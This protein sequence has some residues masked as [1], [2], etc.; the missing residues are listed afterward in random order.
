MYEKEQLEAHEE[1]AN[2]LS[3]LDG[4]RQGE[5]MIHIEAFEYY[6][7]LGN[8]RTC[9]LVG[10]K[11]NKN[12]R[13]ISQW[14][15]KFNWVERVKMRDIE[16]SKKLVEKTTNAIID[17]KANYRKV[18]KLAMAKMIKELQS[19]D[20]KSRGIQDLE[21]LIK[22]DMLLMGENTE[23]VEVEN[24]HAIT[25]EDKEALKTLSNNIGSFLKL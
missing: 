2:K 19:E 1:V 16:V 4:S 13:T 6:Y 21:R 15:S 12:P 25:Q 14:C 20:F 24:K 18:I 10:K 23:K 17:E 3:Y 22:L 5:K 9:A 7:A 11:F 8:D